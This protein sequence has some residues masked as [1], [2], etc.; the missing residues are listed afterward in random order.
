MKVLKKLEIFD[1]R[2][3][4]F[5]IIWLTFFLKN[6][7][8]SIFCPGAQNVSFFKRIPFILLLTLGCIEQG[9]TSWE[10][11]GP[12]ESEEGK[13]LNFSNPSQLSLLYHL[14]NEIWSYIFTFLKFEEMKGQAERVCKKFRALALDR[15]KVLASHHPT[16]LD[17][18]RKASKVSA[19]ASYHLALLFEKGSEDPFIPLSPHSAVKYYKAAAHQNH[20]VAQCN[21]GVYFMKGEEVEKSPQE[22][23][24]LFKASYR[25]GFMG[26][27]YNLG[28][29]Y[30]IQKKFK[31][32]L[33]YFKKAAQAGDFEASYQIAFLHLKNQIK[34]KKK[35][36]DKENNHL[37]TGL[38]LLTS[39][40]SREHQASE[41]IMGFLIE[42]YAQKEFSKKQPKRQKVHQD[43][44]TQ[45]L[46]ESE[47]NWLCVLQENL[48][49][50]FRFYEE[51]ELFSKFCSLKF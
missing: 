19:Q 42:K 33:K 11:K 24:K 45:S 43:V 16:H 47:E 8:K 13:S 28:A 25:Q 48:P 20:P 14:P 38:A 39:L 44:E 31:K 23:L 10:E 49:C 4:P 9:Q 35:K 30:M 2:D 5:K 12:F 17:I 3:Y 40:T 26:G 6:R 50:L 1:E 41:A 46:V 29:Y 27:A 15:Y 37:L 51:R 32:S 18:N 34:K 22:A 7:Q 36:R 21:L